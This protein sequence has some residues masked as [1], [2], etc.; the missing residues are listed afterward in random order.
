MP[1]IQHSEAKAGFTVSWDY[2]ARHHLKAK[3]QHRNKYTESNPFSLPQATGI[4][5]FCKRPF[6]VLNFSSQNVC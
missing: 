6:S 1:I 3:N 2:I 4:L 5:G